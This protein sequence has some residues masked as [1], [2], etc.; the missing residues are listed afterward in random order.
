MTAERPPSSRAS[1][2]A[3][4][5]DS[6]SVEVGLSQAAA[7]LGCGRGLVTESSTFDAAMPWDAIQ[8]HAPDRN[9]W[10]F[11]TFDAAMPCPSRPP[12]VSSVKQA[13][14]HVGLPSP[15]SARLM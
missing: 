4:A 11:T 2:S 15:T 8:R 9:Q 3:S 5:C 13:V 10:R 7:S 6:F 1:S 14:D 12:S